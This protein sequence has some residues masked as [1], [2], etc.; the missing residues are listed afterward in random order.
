MEFKNF[1]LLYTILSLF[2]LF[3]ISIDGQNLSNHLM[4][5]PGVNV[6]NNKLR[7]LV[8][9]NYILI[10]YIQD[11]DYS[12]TSFKSYNRKCREAIS[13]ITYN[14]NSY[15][16]FKGKIKANES[17]ELH[18]SQ[19]TG[20]LDYCFAGEYAFIGQNDY[21]TNCQ[22][23]L[24]VDFSHFDSSALESARL[25]FAYC[26]S[27]QAI[28]FTNF[29]TTNLLDMRGMFKECKVLISLDISYFNPLGAKN[30]HYME[31]FSSLNNLK[32]LNIYKI[33]NALLKAELT[34][35]DLNKKD[36]IVI[37]QSENIMNNVKAIYSCSYFV[38]S[39][40]RHSNNYIIVKYKDAVNYT[41]GF[42]ND[43]I[44]SRNQIDYIIYQ[45]SLFK[46]IDPL[47]IKANNSIEIHFPDKITSLDDFFNS[48]IDSN[49][50]SIIN[51][52][53][54]LLNTSLI[55]ST[56]KMF[57]L[58]TSYLILILN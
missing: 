49:C 4:K 55:I 12:S 11:V 2:M 56:S 1:V 40:L 7:K 46:I 24:Y 19:P 33:Q 34:N 17:V 39:L 51:V 21:D 15:D 26:Y 42:I 37:C 58:C 5:K 35:S 48:Q 52:D 22:K 18:F 36:N 8:E 57:L 50:K 9:D 25:L 13:S 54:S 29:K 23:L 38:E 27:L 28:N 41:S 32:Y 44:P 6:G 3:P 45:D 43:N 16:N 20:C 14:G 47:M 53:L 31:A 30:F 10:T